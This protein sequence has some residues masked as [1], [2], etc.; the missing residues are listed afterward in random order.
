MIMAK[1]PDTSPETAGNPTGN[2]GANG[3][4][5]EPP[6]LDTSAAGAPQPGALPSMRVL[7]QYL[8]DLS[9][10]NPN[11]PQSLGNQQ[12]Q[13]DI[14]VAVN[15]NARNM[16]PTDFEVELHLDAKAMVKDKVIFAAEVLYAGIFRLE[17]FPQNVLHPA[18][19][20][21]CP[22]MLFPF[23]RQVLADATRN[24][25]FP[26]LMLDPIDFAVMYQKRMSAQK[27]DTT[28]TV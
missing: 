19:L 17:N 4:A 9:F 23:A 2:G 14:N 27:A 24:G 6:A 21:E 3:S 22:R 8:K 11:A 15:V 10:E 26:P 16:T 5:V 25:G 28:A 13:P 7:G 1:A 18:V 12:G 20:I